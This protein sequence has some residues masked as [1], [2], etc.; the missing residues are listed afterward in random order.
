[1]FDPL[2]ARTTDTGVRFPSGWEEI[3][4]RR[5]GVGA[6]GTHQAS[7]RQDRHVQASGGT[8]EAPARLQPPAGS[9]PGV[10]HDPVLRFRDAVRRAAGRNDH[11]SWDECIAAHRR[12]EHRRAVRADWQKSG[13]QTGNSQSRNR[14]SLNRPG[15][16]AGARNRSTRRRRHLQALS[17]CWSIA[18]LSIS[19]QDAMKSPSR[20]NSQHAANEEMVLIRRR[21]CELPLISWAAS[22]ISANAAST[23]AAKRLPSPVRLSRD[24]RL[25]KSVTPSSSEECGSD[26]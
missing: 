8:N 4:H 2:S 23:R 21:L 6:E 3:R 16:G 18:S 17:A 12:A 13:E 5:F 9:T 10:E 25:L 7:G 19:G 14:S 26:G 20:G 11:G 15:K 24:R 1:M 22:S